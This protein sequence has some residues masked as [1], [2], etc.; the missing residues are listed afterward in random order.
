MIDALTFG[1]FPL[2]IVE[3]ASMQALWQDLRYG[4][5]ML[6]KHYGFTVVAILILAL[7]IGARRHHK[8]GPGRSSLAGPG[9][10][11]S[12]ASIDAR[13]IAARSRRCGEGA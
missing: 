13:W 9:T 12:P 1:G 2:V 5:R 3:E 7:G 10:A 8:S 6:R 11:R 4:V